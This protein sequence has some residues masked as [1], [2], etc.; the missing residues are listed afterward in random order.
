MEPFVYELL[1]LHHYLV[2]FVVFLALMGHNAVNDIAHFPFSI[3]ALSPV[4]LAAMHLALSR[5]M[6]DKH[7]IRN[8]VLFVW[9]EE[10]R[11]RD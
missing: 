2:E 10:E 7:W 9:K 1:D 8:F 5:Q 4:V 3:A 11:I 6:N